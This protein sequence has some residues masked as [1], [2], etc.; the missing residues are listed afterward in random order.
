MVGV[1]VR[2]GVEGRES[3]VGDGNNAAERMGAWRIQINSTI[4]NCLVDG[5]FIG[6]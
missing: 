6:W 3:Y 5:G 2:R 1:Y 4:G